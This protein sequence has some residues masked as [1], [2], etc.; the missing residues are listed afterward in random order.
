MY[1]GILSALVAGVCAVGLWACSGG[2][3]P[4]TPAAPAAPTVVSVILSGTAPRIG[5]TAQL[6]AR[7]TMSTGTTQDVTSQATWQSSNPSIA[8]VNSTGVVTGMSV[9]ESDISA[10]YQTVRG[11]LH[12][13]LQ[14]PTF[15]LTGTITDATSGGRL[16][17]AAVNLAGRETVATDAAG[18]YSFANVSGGSVTV[19][20]A[21]SGYQT[22]NK[23]A[24][25]SAD[26]RVDLA[27]ARATGTPAPAP[28][29]SPSPSPAPTPAPGSNICTVSS[30]IAAPCGTA[31]ARCNDGSYSCSQNRSGTCSQH[32]G[33]S[34][35]IC[36]GPLCNGLTVGT[37]L[38]WGVK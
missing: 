7:A 22:A 10:T 16:S 18:A 24:I 38:P 14:P 4:A 30:P 37:D 27:L 35:W 11:V 32:N 25:V 34:C 29:P 23:Q 3:G 36:P 15:T 33:V 6:S 28:S 31:T 26:T 2:N 5:A 9:G 1:R 20:A 13:S 17:G 21:A 12:V 19:T 8:V